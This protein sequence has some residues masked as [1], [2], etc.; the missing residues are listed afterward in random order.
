VTTLKAQLEQADD[1]ATFERLS[2]LP[3]ELRATIYKH[4][5]QSLDDSLARRGYK[6]QPPITLVSRQ[7]RQEALPLFYEHSTFIMEANHDLDRNRAA[8]ASSATTRAFIAST[9][10][11]FARIKKL[12]INLRNRWGYSLY[13]DL[14]LTNKEN[15]V[16]GYNLCAYPR[17]SLENSQKGLDCLSELC[18]KSKAMAARPM[19]I[20]VTD[21]EELVMI[22]RDHYCGT[23]RIG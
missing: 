11:H 19:R 20:Q 23:I 2:D 10:G 12:K 3:P 13:I 6:Y 4:Y 1:D 16:G 9:T 15:P 21:V 14:D 7:V 17:N 18:A 8:A 22:L 5:F